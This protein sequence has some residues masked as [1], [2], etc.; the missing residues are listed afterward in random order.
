MSTQVS[1]RI[2]PSAAERSKEG[3]VIGFIPMTSYCE[4]AALMK[5]L[6][7]LPA[8]RDS[9]MAASISTPTA[10]D[11]LDVNDVELERFVASLKEQAGAEPV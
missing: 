2:Y 3:V 7:K 8:F 4:A 1:I 9:G 11:N 6:E 5:R 10:R